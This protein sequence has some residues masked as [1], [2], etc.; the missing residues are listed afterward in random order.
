MRRIS[1]AWLT[2]V[3]RGRRLAG[4]GE[5]LKGNRQYAGVVVVV[6]VVAAVVAAVVVV[7]VVVVVVFVVAVA[8]GSSG[9]LGR[10]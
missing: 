1:G 9:N 10:L 2:E 4:R 6:V 8:T 3:R 7:V 5:G